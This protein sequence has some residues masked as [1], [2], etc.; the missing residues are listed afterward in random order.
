MGGA[1]GHPEQGPNGPL[2]PC[3]RVLQIDDHRHSRNLGV[4][5]HLLGEVY[6]VGG[7]TLL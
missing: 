2:R 4:V 7:N 1:D 5:G 6:D 3:D